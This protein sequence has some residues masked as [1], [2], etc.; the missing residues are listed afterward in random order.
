MIVPEYW[1][2]ARRQRPR[3]KGQHQI[4]VRRFGW[5]NTSQVDAQQMAD[6][7]AD[8]ALRQ[9]IG[10]KELERRE[11]KV[12]Y[13]GAEGV[14]IREEILFSQGDTV[15]TRN[16]YGAHCLNTPDVLFADVDLK[17]PSSST[18]GCGITLLLAAG[19]IIAGFV[20]HSRSI[21]FA[22]FFAA[23]VAG[24]VISQVLKAGA[25][26]KKPGEEHL[27]RQRIEAALKNF[28]SWRVRLYRTPAGFR[29]VVTHRLFKPEEPEVAN[30]FKA[31]GADPVYVQMC[32]RQKCFRA[33]VS[34]K[35]WRIGI[36]QHMRPN[37]GVW[38]VQP[39]H[40]AKRTAWVAEYEKAAE[41]FASCRYLETFGSS[42]TV[43][44]KA[45]A[46]CELHDRLSQALSNREIA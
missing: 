3:A 30:F 24:V 32:Q 1:A 13:N 41:K 45:A 39:E 15:V 7:R 20:T 21:G 46:V 16:G 25:A 33:R 12:G 36:A 10:G 44:T 43:N 22:A 38:P 26:R 6:Q 4:T 17:T 34:P 23:L 40:M 37:P 27:V 28:A 9:I 29:L 18:L 31:L 2:E 11:P 14:P 8:D 35:P 19:A 42:I 5:S